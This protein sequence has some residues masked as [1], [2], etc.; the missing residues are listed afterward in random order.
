[1][2]NVMFNDSSFSVYREMQTHG[3][4]NTLKKLN[5]LLTDMIRHPES[6]I[7][8]VERMKGGGNRYSRRINEK[9]RIVYTIQDDG[10]ILVEQ[11]MGHYED[12]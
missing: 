3:D 11:V 6:G 4:R 12:K 1:M 2:P 8:Q 10:N 9:D 5:A 7:G